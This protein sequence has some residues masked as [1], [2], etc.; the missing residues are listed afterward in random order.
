MRTCRGG[1]LRI[2]MTLAPGDIQWLHNHQIWHARAAYE[3]W[4]DEPYV[5]PPIPPAASVVLRAFRLSGGGS[6]NARAS[7]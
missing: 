2:D 3:D 1:Q 4:T 5:L 6:S 7:A